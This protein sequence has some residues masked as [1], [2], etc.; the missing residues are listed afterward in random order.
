MFCLHVDGSLTGGAYKWE[1]SSV[2]VGI[3]KR[4]GDI[5]IMISA[6]ER[7]NQLGS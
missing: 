5:Q 3:A 6:G 7:F 1:G 2:T 4:G